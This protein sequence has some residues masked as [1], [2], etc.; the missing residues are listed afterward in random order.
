MDLASLAGTSVIDRLV[1]LESAAA[2]LTALAAV[3]AGCAQ[4]AREQADVAR[5]QAD[6]AQ[7]TLS[8]VKVFLALLP[9]DCRLDL[10]APRPDA[11]DP[12]LRLGVRVRQPAPPAAA[13]PSRPV[14]FSGDF[15]G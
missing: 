5:Q 9:D 8:A 15:I 13:R 1:V 11:A 14:R 10:I 3:A 12:A 4:V 6:S 2:H 7:A